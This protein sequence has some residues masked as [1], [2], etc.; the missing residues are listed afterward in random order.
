MAK[1]GMDRRNFLKTGGV[2]LAALG[3]PGIFGNLVA[4]DST[5]PPN[6]VYIMADDLGIRHLGC[7]GGDK[8]DTPNI[9]RL[10]GQGVRFTQAYAGC[11]VCAPSRCTLMTGL[12]TGHTPMRS[13][14]GGVPIRDEVITLPEVLKSAGYATGGYGKW[15][16]GEINT[17]GVPVD[18]G[19]DEFVGYYHQIHAHFYY[20]E[21]I[22][23]NKMKWPLPGNVAGGRL[24]GEAKGARSQYAPDEILKHSLNFIRA[25][26]DR[27]FFCYLS[28][29]LPHVELA[30]PDKELE[31][32]YHQRFGDEEAFYEPREG[33]QGSP[34]PRATYAAMIEHLDRN[35][36]KVLDLLDEL[37]ISDNTVVMFTSDNGGQGSYGGAGSEFFEFFESMKPYRGSKG[38]LYEGGIRVP[39][40][41]RWPG[42][43]SAGTT[44]DNLPLYFPDILPTMAEMAGVNALAGIDGV[45]IVPTLTG[46]DKKQKKHEYLY[47][48]FGSGEYGRGKDLAQAAR[49]GNYK[50]VRNSTSDPME[51]YD[52]DSDPGE[53]K[54]IAADKPEIAARMA[55]ILDKS[56]RDPPPQV[57]PVKVEGTRY[58]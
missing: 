45:S 34:Y 41:V 14:D 54:N 19:F 7:Y 33:Y 18:Q 4:A 10:A 2:G 30:V 53:T 32:K 55:E 58:F 23:K 3:L 20:P 24:P 56:H 43:T 31:E 37:G 21:Y 12:H 22:W 35:V 28:T 47:W 9:D 50:A 39:F 27:P 49:M 1:P 13:N 36:G 48:E 8:I 11:T 42:K 40:I 38:L 6:I 57:E 29:I 15:G 17:S 46:N 52:L 25:N 44:N 26:A 16:L 5:R 51:L